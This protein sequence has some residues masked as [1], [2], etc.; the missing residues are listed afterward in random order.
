MSTE[1]TSI[2][3]I[4]GGSWATALVKIL[5]EGNTRI[6]WWLRSKH[7]IEHIKT[8]G[9]NPSYLSDVE[10]DSEKV[11]PTQQL[12]EA[13]AA[14]SHVL[15]V[16]PS[17]FVVEVLGKLQPAD[18]AGKVV[19]SAVKGM[20]AGRNMLV[21]DYIQEQFGVPASHLLVIAGPCHAEEVAQE[22]QS[23][24]TIGGNDLAQ[25]EFFASLLRCHYIKAYPNLDL[26][27]AQY[28]AVLK[29]IVALACGIARGLNYG[30]NFQSVLVSNAMQE[31]KRFLDK[32]RPET[33]R[34]LNESAYLG[35]LLVTAYSQFS[36]N[37]TFGN[38]IGR[39]Y[40]VKSAQVEMNMIAE[41]YYAVKAVYQ[42]NK[43]HFQAY[44]PIVDAVYHIL[45][46][47]I[48]PIVEFRILK[49][50]LK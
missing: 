23:Y 6:H 40:S 48:S 20:I 22:R 3:I 43:Q 28:A 46:E 45:Y 8:H 32:V 7:D 44:T 19:I 37:R 1:T 5:S 49:D 15:L 34:D 12:K 35:D 36:R 10:I 2:A 21:T 4:G 14:A 9:R 25:A 26:D 50:K 42:A 30:D 29:N 47:K 17:A 33:P 41:G 13:V 38:M 31:M 39:G 18:L 11:F 24:L 27:G 16:I